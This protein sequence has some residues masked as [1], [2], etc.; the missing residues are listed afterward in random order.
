M[1]KDAYASVCFMTTWKLEMI[2]RMNEISESNLGQFYKEA[3]DITERRDNSEEFFQVLSLAFGQE[4]Y[5]AFVLSCITQL[6][7]S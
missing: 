2:Q 7:K 4:N 6:P 3:E 5:L 1:F